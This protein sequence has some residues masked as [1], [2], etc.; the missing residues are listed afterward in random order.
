MRSIRNSRTR[1]IL[2]AVR[3]A[4]LVMKEKRKSSLQGQTPRF[5]RHPPDKDF[6]VKMCLL[7]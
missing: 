5:P 2:E 6:I 3:I 7:I 1:K 4:A